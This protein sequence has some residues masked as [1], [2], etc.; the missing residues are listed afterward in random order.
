MLLKQNKASANNTIESVA[1][2]SLLFRVSEHTDQQI[3]GKMLQQVMK[4]YRAALRKKQNEESIYNLDDLLQ[5]RDKQARNIEQI[6]E[7]TMMGYI[8][9]SIMI[10]SVLWLAEVM[11]SEAIKRR[12]WILN[13]PFIRMVQSVSVSQSYK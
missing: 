13:D 7:R 6:S 4:K 8:F 12:Q 10:F 11:R 3:Q 2:F 5:I 1:A 9:V